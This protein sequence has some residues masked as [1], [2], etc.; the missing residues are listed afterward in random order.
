MKIIAIIVLYKPNIDLMN[1]VLLSINTQVNNIILIN[2]GCEKYD[3]SNFDNIESINLG[4]NFGI[5]YAQNRGIE[6]ALKLG[7]DYVLLS[8]QDTIYPNDYI[9]SFLSFISKNMAD[10]YCPVFY[11]NIKNTYSPIMVRKFNS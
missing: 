9:T 7:A 6:K 3:F 11:D 10:V 2:N 8:D 5:A 1:K 4:D